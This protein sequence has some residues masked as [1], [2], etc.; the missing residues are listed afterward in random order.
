MDRISGFSVSQGIPCEYG[1]ADKKETSMKH[2]RENESKRYA[3]SIDTVSI[4]D[5]ARI[6]SIREK[7]DKSGIYADENMLSRI[8]SDLSPSGG[9]APSPSGEFMKVILNR[10][11]NHEDTLKAFAERYA[12]VR[13]DILKRYRD[14]PDVLNQKLD[15]LDKTFK[16]FLGATGNAPLRPGAYIGAV[17]LSENEAEL[18][19]NEALIEARAEHKRNL[20]NMAQSF[21]DNM[22]RHVDAFFDSFTA[23]ISEQGFETAFSQSMALLKGTE[24]G[25]HGALSYNDTLKLLEE[26][27][28]YK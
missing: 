5:D 18:K 24:T 23:A 21:A 28:L 27:L 13:E 22:H 1:H 20:N 17:Y 9:N 12:F 16:S 7:L 8:A 2:N 10:P 3:S 11:G 14:D 25:S 6:L 15:E 19:A 4:S 26:Y